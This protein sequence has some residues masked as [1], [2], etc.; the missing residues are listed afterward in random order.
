[1]RSLPSILLLCLVA[2]AAAQD[3]AARLVAQLHDE[4]HR[5]A[6][7]DRLDDLGD[8]VLPA[9]AS[10]LDLCLDR[11]ET[12]AATYVLLAI[13][14]LGRVSAPLAR[15]LAAH[16]ADAPPALLVPMLRAIGAMGPAGVQ[17]APDLVE[18]V[19]NTKTPVG[20][21]RQ[22]WNLALARLEFA[23]TD[24]DQ[25]R[26]M[27]GKRQLVPACVAALW[28]A[29]DPARGEGLGDALLAAHRL[30]LANNRSDGGWQVEVEETALAV[31]RSETD[32]VQRELAWGCLLGYHDPLVRL[33]AI[34]ALRRDP[35]AAI[36]AVPE[37]IRAL[38]DPERGVLREVMIT[39]GFFS[40]EALA[41][42]P[43]LARWRSS[44]DAEL[45][46]VAAAASQSIRANLSS[47]PAAVAELLDCAPADAAR[48]VHRVAAFG[49]RAKPHL[50]ALLSTAKDDLRDRCNATLAAL[51][52]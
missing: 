2:R 49:P 11:G 47:V 22:E 34:V 37:L 12:A 7:L 48:A 36:T 33:E 16:L 45:Q 10:D 41:A 17:H 26:G 35:G 13:E 1:M 21:T 39:L 46:R 43:V 3:D 52:R 42:L 29:E 5:L 6:A 25:L 19:R 32:P 51:A 15:Q 50:E 27:L 18:H 31:V 40:D 24:T 14:R 4:R 44:P 38:D 20:R 9:L 8:A 28:I 23:A 30:A